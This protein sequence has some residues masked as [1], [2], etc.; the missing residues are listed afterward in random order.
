M[1]A[2]ELPPSGLSP[3]EQLARRLRDRLPSLRDLRADIPEELDALVARCTAPT[4]EERFARSKEVVEAL[5]AVPVVPAGPG[6]WSGARGRG[7]API[8]GRARSGA[9][10]RHHCCGISCVRPVV[11][12]Q[13]VVVADRK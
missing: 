9:G 12:S 1:L 3:N 10:R 2:G 6:F 4:P 7:L 13:R 5:I 11:G 8:G